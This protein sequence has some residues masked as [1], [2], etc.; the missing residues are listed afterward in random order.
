MPIL[1]L[2]HVQVAAPMRLGVED[3]ARAFYGALLGLR[4]IEKPAALKAKGGVWFSLGQGELHVG[5]EE[6][7]Q[8][9]RKAHPALLV[10]NLA[11]M[12]D[13][14][15]EAGVQIAEAEPISGASRFY[16]Y[17]P[18]GNRIELIERT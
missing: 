7:F 4:E 8:P 9:A 15:E 2:D 3:E 13:R 18:F 1:G 14:L 17:D 6:Q 10:S 11:A 5:L 16:V 12:H